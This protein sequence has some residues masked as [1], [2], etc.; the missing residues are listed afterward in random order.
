MAGVP[1]VAGRHRHVKARTAPDVDATKTKN[2]AA[3]AAD[4][5]EPSTEPKLST[6]ECRL[7]LKK[8]DAL[9]S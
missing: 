9:I 3:S 7:V 4:H 5:H 1:N 6:Q 8:T 2:A